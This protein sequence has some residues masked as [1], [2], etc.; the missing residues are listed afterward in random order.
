MRLIHFLISTLYKLFVCLLNFNSFLIY[1]L[2][3]ITSFLILFSSLLMYFL[4]HLLSDLST[5]F[6]LDPFTFHFSRPLYLRNGANLAIVFCVNLCCSGMHIGFVVLDLVF[7][8]L[9]KSL[10][11]KN[12]SKITYLVSGET[13]NLNQSILET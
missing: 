12:V 7:Q 5:L 8:Y 3:L 2:S 9:S 6:R 13:Q 1:F 11:G 4:S 10:A